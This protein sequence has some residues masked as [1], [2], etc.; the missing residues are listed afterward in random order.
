MKVPIKHLAIIALCCIPSL[1]VNAQISY[2]KG[3]PFQA[4]KI[5]TNSHSGESV[6]R[7]ALVGRSSNGSTYE[8]FLDAKTGTPQAILISDV[9]RRRRIALYFT[10]GTYTMGDFSPPSV[11]DAATPNEV[12]KSIE[13]VKKL[14][15]MR[16]SMEGVGATATPLGIRTQDGFVESGKRL[17]LDSIP[18]GSSLKEKIWESWWIPALSITVENTGFDDN[19][20]PSM[21]TR[22]TNIQT[23][24]PDP[25]LFEIPPG[26]TLAKPSTPAK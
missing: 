17:V 2:V 8:E 3:A 6:T 14:Q 24:E 20:M 26:F 15:P 9:P 10:T 7:Q 25:N 21:S 22:L 18:T 11:P 13:I 19:N 12:K 4:T 5:T 23:T 1:A 16:S